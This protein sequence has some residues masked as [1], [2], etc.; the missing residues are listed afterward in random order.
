[1]KQES[2]EGKEINA[3]RFCI[4]CNAIECEIYFSISPIHQVKCHELGKT[5]KLHTFTSSI[6]D[7]EKKEL[8]LIPRT[9]LLTSSMYS[10]HARE[11]R[12]RTRAESINLNFMWIKSVWCGWERNYYTWKRE[13]GFACIHILFLPSFSFALA[14]HFCFEVSYFFA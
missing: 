5:T 6:S 12:T 13:Q 3:K 7:E 1:M 10:I 4:T 9:T 8:A 14:A 2:R 11:E